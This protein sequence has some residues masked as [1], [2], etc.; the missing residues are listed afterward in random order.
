LDSAQALAE[1]YDAPFYCEDYRELLA[2]PDIDF[3]TIATPDHLHRDI[4]AAAAQAGKHFMV[5]KPLTTSLAEADELI[6]RVEQSGVKAMTCFNHRWIPAYARAYQEI[7]A[8][9][10][11]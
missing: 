4:C 3:V 10:I 2:R 11:G 1:Q 6:A 8:G 9:N 5:E 7:E